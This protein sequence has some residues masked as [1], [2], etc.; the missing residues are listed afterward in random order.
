MDS[1]TIFQPQTL[2]KLLNAGNNHLEGPGQEDLQQPQSYDDV[3]LELK[4]NGKSVPN[5]LLF[6][7][8]NRVKSLMCSDL[9]R[10]IIPNAQLCQYCNHKAELNRLNSQISDLTDLTE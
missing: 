3:F 10:D 2:H 9:L 5:K 8:N 4:Q 6:N 7:K 1:Q